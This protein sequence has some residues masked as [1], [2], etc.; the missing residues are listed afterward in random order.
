MPPTRASNACTRLVIVSGTIHCWTA[1]ASSMAWYT[2]AWGARIWRDR[3]VVAVTARLRTTRRTPERC[4]NAVAASAPRRY[5]PAGTRHW[6]SFDS[7]WA[8]CELRTVEGRRRASRARPGA[9]RVVER[10]CGWRS[11]RRRS[12]CWREA[13]RSGAGG[14]T[15]TAS[16]GPARRRACAPPSRCR[17]ARGSSRAR[18]PTSP[19]RSP[20]T[21]PCGA[22]VGTTSG[23]SGSGRRPTAASSYKWATG[24]GSR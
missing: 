10:R 4:W 9:G 20:A 3:C 21:T 13:A 12:R 11:P 1:V 19:A 24:R 22:P 14:R 18:G 15:A 17:A 7:G 2:C 16:W 8:A 5:A 23:S 6:D